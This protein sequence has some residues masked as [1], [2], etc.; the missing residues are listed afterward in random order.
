MCLHH[1][2]VYVEQDNRGDVVAFCGWWVIDHGDLDM[3]AEKRGIPV[4]I[5]KG[6][7]IWI[8]DGACSSPGGMA[9][10]QRHLKEQYPVSSGI[11]GVACLRN[12]QRLVV[13]MRWHGVDDISGGLA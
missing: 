9:R 13:N 7:M 4:D 2:Q 5:T 3:V 10:A 8:M 1:N 12:G 6:D 11:K